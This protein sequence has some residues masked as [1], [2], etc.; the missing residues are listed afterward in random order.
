MLL[1]SS[2][3]IK[4]G[5]HK[6]AKGSDC[7]AFRPFAL[8]SSEDTAVFCYGNSN[9]FR[10]QLRISSPN[11]GRYHE[12]SQAAMV[13]LGI[14]H[15]ISGIVF[16]PPSPTRHS[17]WSNCDTIVTFMDL[18]DILLHEGMAL[19]FR[20]CVCAG[21]SHQAHPVRRNRS[22]ACV[23]RMEGLAGL[24]RFLAFSSARHLFNKY[25]VVADR[26]LFHVM[27]AMSRGLILIEICPSLRRWNG[28][29]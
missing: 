5:S 12:P 23:E 27:P 17:V 9:R 3:R 14:A 7:L 29:T 19:C 11:W 10:H 28:C 18:R 25:S 8:F 24:H 20:F 21:H 16:V 15:H 22:V 26:L 4:G 1:L 13:E 2:D 6:H